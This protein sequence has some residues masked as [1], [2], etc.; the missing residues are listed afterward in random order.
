MTHTPPVMSPEL[1][2][3]LTT[4]LRAE[5]S[6]PM[7]VD[8][9]ALILAK[10]GVLSIA[11]NPPPSGGF[12]VPEH[13]QRFAVPPAASITTDRTDP[14]LGHGSD[15]EPRPQNDVDRVANDED[16]KTLVRPVMRSYLHD[17][18]LGGCGAVTTMSLPIAETYAANPQFYGSTYCVGCQ[19]HKRV[20]TGGEFVWV[21]DRPLTWQ[22]G[23]EHA[24]PCDQ[25]IS[26]QRLRVGT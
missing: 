4:A 2:H 23:D 21:D 15:D 16:R 12:P 24:T 1:R 9:I 20:G 18:A 19:M 10:H 17:P 3:E 14:R 22:P 7:Q 11:H 6:V 13:L 26:A 5:R 25:S 8:M